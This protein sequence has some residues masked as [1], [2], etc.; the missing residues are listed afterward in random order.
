MSE[1]RYSNLRDVRYAHGDMTQTEM[2]NKIGISATA[3]AQIELGK[4]HGK[5][6]TWAN[7]QNVFGLTDAEVW[8]LMAR[9]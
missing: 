1:R 5:V 8:Q 6:S 4:A 9:K 2:A 7:I 3:Y